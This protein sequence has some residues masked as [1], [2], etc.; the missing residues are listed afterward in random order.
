MAWKEN[1]RREN[2]HQEKSEMIIQRSYERERIEIQEK[3]SMVER[4]IESRELKME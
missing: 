1:G 2:N 3:K 4:K